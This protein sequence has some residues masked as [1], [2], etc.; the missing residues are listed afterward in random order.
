MNDRSMSLPS[1]L[2]QQIKP[3]YRSGRRWLAQTFHGHGVDELLA[4]VRSLGIGP[5][6][7][8]MM[9]SRFNRESGFKGGPAD[10][11]EGLI[12]AL[13][14]EGHLLMMSMA[15]G[16]ASADY[17]A[18]DP[19][20]DVRRTPSAVG[21][22]TEVFRRRDG[23]L[24]SLNPLHPVLAHGPLAEWIVADHDKC[25]LSCGKGSP[26]ERFLK[27][28]GKFL[29]LDAPYAALTFMHFVEDHFRSRLP[30][31]LYDSEPVTVRVRDHQERERRLRHHCFGEA[32]RARRHFAPIEERLRANG[33]M[34]ELRVG[35]SRLLG[36]SARDVFDC[37]ADLLER[38]TGF[39]R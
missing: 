12:D 19:L 7:S 38:G 22:L 28:D 15:Y 3:Y 29:F 26:F 5:G 2:K 24:R 13:G 6:D 11:V 27:L 18:G 39:Y 33:R 16:G 31:E 30:V 25:M 14:P 8:V 34:R 9:H 4:A 1:R 35:R 17:C 37:A 21:L 36:V 10:I 20:F 23:V 32:A